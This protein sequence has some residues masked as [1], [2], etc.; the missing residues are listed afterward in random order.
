M[1]GNVDGLIYTMWCPKP[2]PSFKAAEQKAIDAL[3]KG[4]EATKEE[5]LDAKNGLEKTKYAQPPLS[6]QEQSTRLSLHMS[7][8]ENLA[9]VHGMSPA[10]IM[11]NSDAM[12]WGVG[13]MAASGGGIAAGASKGGGRVFEPAITRNTPTIFAP[14]AKQHGKAKPAN[15]AGSGKAATAAA[16]VGA[17][18][19]AVIKQ[20]IYEEKDFISKHA[21]DRHKFDSNRESTKSRTQYNENVDP[22]KIREETLK[23]P[24]DF[25]K[26]IDKDG[27]HYATRYSKDMGYNIAQPPMNTSQSRVFVNHINPENSSQFPYGK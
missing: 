15:G 7:V 26:L 13:S 24:D 14:A 18:E 20:R 19:G 2:P 3:K 5:L 22:N 23:N 1:A 6:M 16:G 25:K 10:E 9:S 17:V 4:K 11:G 27:N 12:T 8:S 21:Y